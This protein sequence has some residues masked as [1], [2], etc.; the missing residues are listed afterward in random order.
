MYHHAQIFIF[1]NNEACSIPTCNQDLIFPYS[2]NERALIVS[3]ARSSNRPLLPWEHLRFQPWHGPWDSKPSP[4]LLMKNPFVLKSSKP[5]RLSRQCILLDMTLDYCCYELSPWSNSITECPRTLL[6]LPQAS[7]ALSI[8]HTL[9]PRSI[10]WRNADGWGWGRGRDGQKVGIHL[11]HKASS[12]FCKFLPAPLL[13]LPHS[14]LMQRQRTE[15]PPMFWSLASTV[16]LLAALWP[17][18]SLPQISRRS[19]CTSHHCKLE[20]TLPESQLNGGGKRFNYMSPHCSYSHS[21]CISWESSWLKC[22]STCISALMS[23]VD[24]QCDI[25]GCKCYLRTNQ[26]EI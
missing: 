15:S 24:Q 3:P 1:L 19:V 23:D 14:C 7:H 18:G 17:S 8:C 2:T 10:F 26:G 25:Q 16:Q 5:I 22:H 4:C 21:I 11:A 12:C 13:A 6:C 20:I 9:Q